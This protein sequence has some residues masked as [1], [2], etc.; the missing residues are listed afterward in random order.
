MPSAT[1]A[2]VLAQRRHLILSGDIDG[3]ADLFTPDGV[4]ESPFAPPGAP[5]R[6]EGREAICEYSRHVMASPLRLE[7][8]QV[9]ELYQTQDR[10]W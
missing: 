5:S 7:E 3:Y 10:R 8:Y 1:P 9:V 2:D 6:L 4:I